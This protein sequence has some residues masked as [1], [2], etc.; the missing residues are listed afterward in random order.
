MLDLDR[1]RQHDGI[2]WQP[3]RQHETFRRRADLCERLQGGAKPADLNTQP[4]PVGFV[5]MAGTECT[6]KQK[7]PRRVG[8]SRFS[9][10]ARKGKKHRPAHK[11]YDVSST[12]H[13]VA[14]GVHDKGVGRQKRLDLIQR[15]GSF[16]FFS[17]QARGGLVE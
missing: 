3:R 5:G 17:H 15:Q 14:T 10:H 13:D 16:A 4:R 11:R 8:R 12:A 6:G 2:T 1:R 7:R 9:E